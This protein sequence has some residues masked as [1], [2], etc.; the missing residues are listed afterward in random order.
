M[1]F[2]LVMSSL[3]ALAP[4]LANWLGMTPSAIYER[5]RALV[6]IRVMSSG[7]GR[8]PGS[9]VRAT[10]ANTALLL[11]AVLATDSLWEAGQR[12]LLI[13]AA[14]PRGHRRC[15]L[16]G[17]STFIEALTHILA[18]PSLAR[19]LS[20]VRVSRSEIHA[21]IEYTEPGGSHQA[22]REHSEFGF[23]RPGARGLWTEAIL[24]GDVIL[25]VSKAIDKQRE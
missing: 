22:R 4:E 14:A 25:A 18:L 15:K 11:T 10:P 23:R 2:T 20:E 3:K 16:T 6:E 24:S 9:G 1:L 5:Q 13:S 7:S 8:G 17:K 19:E 21:R 12:V